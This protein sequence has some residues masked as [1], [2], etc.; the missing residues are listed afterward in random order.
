MIKELPVARGDGPRSRDKLNINKIIST[1]KK[2]RRET[3]R[4]D[5]ML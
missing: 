1:R 2:V 4:D 5:E 3:R